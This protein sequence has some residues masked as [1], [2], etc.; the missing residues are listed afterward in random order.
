MK[1]LIHK[2]IQEDFDYIHASLKSEGLTEDQMNFISDNTW[3]TDFGFFSYRF[4]NGMPRLIH[5]YINPDKRN[6]HHAYL[7]WHIF[8]LLM[9]KKG[10]FHAILEVPGNKEYLRSF[11]R[12]LGSPQPFTEQDGAEFYR[13]PLIGRKQNE[14]LQ[15]VSTAMVG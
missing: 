7:L 1:Q 5:F 9:M 11:M 15:K 12:L 14:D 3:I 10:H 8:A 2:Y 6:Y 4:D 13:V